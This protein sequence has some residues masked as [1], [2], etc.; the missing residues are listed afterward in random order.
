MCSAVLGTNG[1]FI[2]T[3]VPGKHGPD[4]IDTDKIM[5]N[6]VLK[7]QC[8]LGTVNAGKDAF[9]KAVADLTAFH[10]DMARRGEE[11]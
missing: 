3:G 1:L 7:N 5:R 11:V 8:V 6:L 4:S 2:L 10:A 9:Q